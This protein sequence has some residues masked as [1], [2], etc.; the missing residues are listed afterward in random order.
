MSIEPSLT[1]LNAE[2][3]ILHWNI[4]KQ[5]VSV[6]TTGK[7]TLGN[8]QLVT[9]I[10]PQA[11]GSAAQVYPTLQFKKDNIVCKENLYIWN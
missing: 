3:D 10:Y 2:D 4:Y 6:S 8:K 9:K 5:K 7:E 11:G 1:T